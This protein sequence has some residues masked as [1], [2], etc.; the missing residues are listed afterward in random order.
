ML[1]M[2]GIYDIL[3]Y[4][5]AENDVCAMKWNVKISLILKHFPDNVKKNVGF[6]MCIP[7][8]NVLELLLL[9]LDE[10]YI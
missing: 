8:H 10:L 2:H 5:I 3:V 4:E 7:L 9:K 6:F 1:Y